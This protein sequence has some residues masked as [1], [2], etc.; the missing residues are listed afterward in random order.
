MTEQ[1]TEIEFVDQPTVCIAHG[2]FIPC[3][4]DGEHRYTDNPFWVKSVR[5]YQTSAI[6]GLTWEPAW[7]RERE[8]P[9]PAHEASIDLLAGVRCQMIH[10]QIAGASCANCQSWARHIGVPF[11]APLL[12]EIAMAAISTRPGEPT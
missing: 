6:G 7:E 10:D 2:A 3:R 12:A 4:E 9:S 5:E 11:W 1:K 8:A